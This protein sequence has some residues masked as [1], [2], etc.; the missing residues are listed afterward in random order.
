MKT[1]S[2]KYFYEDE[3]GDSPLGIAGEIIFEGEY[4]FSPAEP[5]VMYYKDGSGYPGYPT[6]FEL[7]GFHATKLDKTPLTK[8]QGES[9]GDWLYDIFTSDKYRDN[10]IDSITEDIE[11]DRLCNMEIDQ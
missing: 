4:N 2:F 3:N 7:Y 11:D 1:G 8:E 6:E 9:V 10:L 5:M